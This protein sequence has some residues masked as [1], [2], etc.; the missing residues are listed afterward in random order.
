MPVVVTDKNVE[1]P[2]FTVLLSGW[3]AMSTDVG[4]HGVTVLRG[5]KEN[6]VVPTMGL[7]QR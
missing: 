3:E 7:A 5:P 1:L 6:Q 2:V 4:G